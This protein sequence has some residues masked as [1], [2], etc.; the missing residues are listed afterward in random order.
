MT[1]IEKWKS[2]RSLFK[3]KGKRMRDEGRKCRSGQP[4]GAV[5]SRH[6][7]EVSCPMTG[8]SVVIASLPAD[9]V[10]TTFNYSFFCENPPC[11]VAI[12]IGR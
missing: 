9:L 8:V 1:W 12:S 2:G 6:Y 11:D 7:Q 5:F 3:D 4:Q 10:G